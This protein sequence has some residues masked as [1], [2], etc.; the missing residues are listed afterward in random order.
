MLVSSIQHNDLRK[1]FLKKESCN[2]LKGQMHLKYFRIWWRIHFLMPGMLVPSL[3]WELKSQ[4]SHQK[5]YTKMLTILWL[6]LFNCI[7]IFKCLQYDVLF[8]EEKSFLI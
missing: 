6:F 5:E 2:H 8:L 7:C 4:K 3:A 1:V